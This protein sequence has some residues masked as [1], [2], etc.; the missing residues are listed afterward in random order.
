MRRDLSDEPFEIIRFNDL[1]KFIPVGKTRR[2]ELIKAD[3]LEVVPL[4]P[5]TTNKKGELVRGRAKGV[6]MRSIR[7]YQALVMGLDEQTA[8]TPAKRS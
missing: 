2:D 8:M 4:T 7:K 3:L 5:D 6:T 1:R